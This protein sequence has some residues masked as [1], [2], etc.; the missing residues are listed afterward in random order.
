[1]KLYEINQAIESLVDIETGEILDFEAFQQLQMERSEKIENIALWIKNLN[2]ESDAIKVEADKLLERKKAIDNKAER[3]KK[4]LFE[5]LSGEKFSS[6]KV[7]VSYRKSSTVE[8]DDSFIDWAKD[9]H[10]EYLKFK[11]PEVDKI[12]V[13][14]AINSGQV[15][16]GARIV[17]KQN[18]QIK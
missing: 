13:K 18:I 2:A 6:S 15:I 5:I 17:D 1:M 8:I 16:V 7:V 3:L 14:Q 10:P 4:Y 11:E 9:N 12:A